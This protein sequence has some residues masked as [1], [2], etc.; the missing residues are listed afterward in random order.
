MKTYQQVRDGID[1]TRSF[2]RQ[3]SNVYPAS[4]KQA[5]KQRVKLLL[6]TKNLTSVRGRVFSVR[7]HC[8]R[9]LL[10]HNAP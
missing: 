8:G 2:H 10:A 3:L 9:F 7:I 6:P 5:E 1:H 4:G